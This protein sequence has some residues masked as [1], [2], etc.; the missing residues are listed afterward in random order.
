MWLAG[1]WEGGYFVCAWPNY[2]WCCEVKWQRELVFPQLRKQ[3]KFPISICRRHNEDILQRC[4]SS[5]F[6]GCGTSRQVLTLSWVLSHVVLIINSMKFLSCYIH[7][8]SQ[9][10]PSLRDLTRSWDEVLLMIP[11]QYCQLLASLC[12]SWKWA[13]PITHHGPLH[14]N[15]QSSSSRIMCSD[16]VHLLFS[17]LLFVSWKYMYVFWSLNKQSHLW[18]TSMHVLCVVAQGMISCVCH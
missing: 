8:S 4:C 13:S 7:V 1:F 17:S 16:C 18:H 6:K 15:K 12:L 2:W 9:W 11:R 10:T 3:R 14:S 5:V